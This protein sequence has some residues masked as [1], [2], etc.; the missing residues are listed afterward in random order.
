MTVGELMDLFSKFS[1][2]DHH[3]P[4]RVC[5][6]MYFGEGSDEDS[7]EWVDLDIDSVD[8]ISELGKPKSDFFRIEIS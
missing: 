5:T 8:K 2:D 1:S 4:V 3:L 7:V 6:K